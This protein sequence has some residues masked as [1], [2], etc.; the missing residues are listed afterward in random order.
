MPNNDHVVPVLLA[1][2][3]TKGGLIF[4]VNKPPPPLGPGLAQEPMIVKAIMQYARFADGQEH[5][6]VFCVGVDGS[7]YREKSRALITKIPYDEVV[8]EDLFLAEGDVERQIAAMIEALD[9]AD[10]M[11]VEETANQASEEQAQP[12]ESQPQG[13][14]PAEPDLAEAHH[15]VPQA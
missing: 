4:Q 8:R 11:A 1:R 5:Y 2:I 15:A 13:D 10:R 9:E 6:W 12:E 14:P 3:V 7:V